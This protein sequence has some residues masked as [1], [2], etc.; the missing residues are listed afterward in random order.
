MRDAEIEKTIHTLQTEN[1]VFE[2][3]CSAA[4]QAVTRE[5][6]DAF[7]AEQQRIT[8]VS[9]RHLGW[10]SSVLSAAGCH[11]TVSGVNLRQVEVDDNL[12][13]C[14]LFLEGSGGVAAAA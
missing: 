7:L 6:T 9:Y 2:K 14:C 10:H 1:V 11:L 8:R 13:W 3:K 4:F 12:T 5:H